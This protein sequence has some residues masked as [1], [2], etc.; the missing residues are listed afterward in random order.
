MREELVMT[1]MWRG[2]RPRRITEQ[3]I[4]AQYDAR[5]PDYKGPRR[6]IFPSPDNY[7]SCYKLVLVAIRR[8][9]AKSIEQFRERIPNAEAEV[10]GQLDALIASGFSAWDNSRSDIKAAAGIRVAFDAIKTKARL[11]GV[12]ID[13]KFALDDDPTNP[14]REAARAIAAAAQ[15]LRQQLAERGVRLP[16]P[17]KAVITVGATRNGAHKTN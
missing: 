13:G 15:E 14:A 5:R 8:I 6:E 3:L 4:A 2:L 17:S 10:L 1:A 11:L 12:S 7:E 16:P 9:K